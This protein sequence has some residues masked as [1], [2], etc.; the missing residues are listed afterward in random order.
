[1]ITQSPMVSLIH[2][3]KVDETHLIEY[4]SKI[5]DF[6]YENGE[7]FYLF[8]S[9]KNSPFLLNFD[10]IIKSVFK[11]TEVTNDLSVPLNYA[12]AGIAGLTTG[13][14]NEWIKSNFAESKECFMK[15]LISICTK[16]QI[17]FF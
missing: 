2:K 8:S 7:V 14:I 9:Y 10:E 3:E 16:A 15:I 13:L 12:A 11:E 1:M 4:F 17:A 6:L 5:V